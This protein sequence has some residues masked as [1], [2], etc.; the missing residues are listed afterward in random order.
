VH[1]CLPA[2]NAAP[3][4]LTDCETGDIEAQIHKI[5]WIA[6]EK[7]LELVPFFWDIDFDDSILP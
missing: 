7:A 5:V 3:L 4:C 1:A 2:E 6:S